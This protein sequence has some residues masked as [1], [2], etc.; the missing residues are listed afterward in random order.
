MEGFGRERAQ[1]YSTEVVNMDKFCIFFVPIRTN[2]FPTEIMKWVEPH[3]LCGF[4]IRPFPSELGYIRH[5]LLIKIFIK[6]KRKKKKIT[7]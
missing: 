4:E 5:C 2:R 3:Y 6:N 1:K 7:V